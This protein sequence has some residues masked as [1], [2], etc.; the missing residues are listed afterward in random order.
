MKTIIAGSRD[1]I[2]ST[3]E[4]AEIVME[5]GFMVTEVVCGKARGIDTCGA[6]WAFF[7][8]IPVAPFPVSRE[9]WEKYGKAA[10]H[11]RNRQM[12]QYADALIAIWDGQSRGTKGMID[13]MK[14]LKKP[15][16]VYTAEDK[17]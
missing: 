9:D 16:Y 13:E 11:R 6:N 1:L 7:R 5:S 2:L 10:G 3:N 15:T 12:A 4:I 17:K 8:D 14:K